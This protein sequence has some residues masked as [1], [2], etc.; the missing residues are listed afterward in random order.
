MPAIRDFSQGYHAGT[1]LRHVEA[2]MPAYEAGDLLL[3]IVSID[4]SA[5][6]TAQ[7]MVGGIPVP[8]IFYNDDTTGTPAWTDYTV[9]ANT[10]SAVWYMTP[11]VPTLNDCINF[12]SLE[13]FSQINVVITTAATA[14]TN[15]VYA[16]QYWNGAWT[17]LTTTT[18]TF[19]VNLKP[20]N[21]VHAE[22]IWA[23]PADWAT[24]AVNGVTAYWVRWICTTANTYTVRGV[25]TQA[26]IFPVPNSNNCWRQLF[27]YYGGTTPAPTTALWKIASE[28]EVDT[29]FFYATAE[30][31]DVELISMR[32]VQIF[33]DSGVAAL[34]VNVVA[35]AGTYIRTT[36]S[37]VTNGFA[38][39]MQISPS[40]F[41]NATNNYTRQIS[42]ITT[43]TNTNDTI[44]VTNVTGLVNETGGGDERIMAWPFNSDV[45]GGGT[46]STF[47]G[48]V[49]SF[50]A[51]AAGRGA[52]PQI[53][54]TKDECLLIYAAVPDA[55]SAPSIIEGPCQLIAGKDGTA[56]A[57]GMA[58]GYQKTAG[59][60]P[61]NVYMSQA[62]AAASGVV[63]E[64]A[65]IA[66][67]PPHTGATV[68]PGYGI[69]D[70]SVY[71]SPYTGAAYG[72]DSA[73]VSA[74][75]AFIGTINGRP[76]SAQSVTF[77]T[78]ADTGLNSYHA[79]TNFSGIVTAGTYG[80]TNTTIATRSIAGKNV[81]FHI[82]TYLP[83][84]I[85]TTDSV[86]LKGACGVVLGLAS[87]TSI[88]KVWHVGGSGVYGDGQRHQPV[89]INTS[90]TAGC[91]CYGGSFAVS[92]GSGTFVA[93][94]RIYIGASW[95]TAT[96]RAKIY[97]VAGTTPTQTIVYN[98]MELANGAY[99]PD[100][101]AS[102]AVVE[103]TIANANGA[104]GTAGTVTSL[105]G[106]A[107][108]RI[109]QYVSGKVVVANWLVGSVW[110][111]DTFTVI[112][113]IAAEPLNLPQIV[114]CYS[115][116]HERK[117][118]IQQGAGQALFLGPVQIG[119]GT[120]FT[121]LNLDGT[122]IE[123]PKQY[124]KAAKQVFYNSVDNVCG[125]K[126][127]AA[128][129][130]TIIHKNSV[131]SS[132]SRYHWGFNS[133]YNTSVTPDF[134]GLSVIGAGTIT[135]NRAVT[136]T[137]LTINDYSTLDVSGL[138][139]D[140]GTIK[141]VPA[142]SASITTTT[143]T[144][145]KRSSI[146]V[147][148]VTAG[149]YWCT[150][151][152][153]VIFENITWTGGGGHAIRITTPGS[154]TLVGNVFNSFGANGTTGAAILNE[155]G[156]LVTITVSSGG[157]GTTY[158]NA[159]GSESTTIIAGAVDLAINVKDI[160]SGS[161]LQSARVLVEVASGVNFPYNASITA[162]A[163]GTTATIAHTGHGLITGKKINVKGAN[164]IEY[165]GVHSITYIGV[166]SYSYTMS[167]SP[168]SPATGTIT[169]TMVLIDAATDV[170]GNVLDNRTYGVNQPIT[171]K[172][173][174]AT[175]PDFYKN[176]P[177]SGTINK[178]SG[179]SLS[180]QMI[181]DA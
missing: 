161:N 143:G 46:G 1:A 69:S 78:R 4:D 138:T 41:T 63:T 52:L 27:A 107:V 95:A 24:T 123:F 14:T 96:K 40:G 25:Y 94:S 83:I 177:V 48:Y 156:G 87:A 131:I 19:G 144:L 166:D 121:Y 85:Q 171:G 154:Y 100:F 122:A 8:Y 117:S 93:T 16:L 18:N 112:G 68:R 70:S 106:G 45:S 97:S 72:S 115:T 179:L 129:G 61:N 36:G 139:F 11:T 38:V 119:D 134:S 57:D 80:G 108:V 66:V 181:P 20:V 39:G 130:D 145:I 23:V 51:A 180:V 105:N 113:G 128:A 173:R 147:S 9:E 50:L 172:V 56:H 30:T 132:S 140:Q 124:D 28:I 151:T 21:T 26:W 81:L 101:A 34:T 168:A 155:S 178:D 162:T 109:G 111:L 103:Y 99:S 141:N 120:N 127:F 118:A 82:Q 174:L 33:A 74:L 163:S 90:A 164:Q 17:T 137:G 84:D 170:N 32:D 165:N 60:T 133:S 150:T 125:L 43:T 5:G 15:P 149:N 126:Y 104:T 59:T 157:S 135:L 86:T 12:G 53:T 54:T 71:I 55:I 44:T 37:W 31:A 148:R 79:M 158:R 152:T 42:T 167:G 146:D 116:G 49:T 153:P 102:D 35:A 65:T 73:P 62:L 6:I 88:F 29:T 98:T 76:I 64:L 91:L 175:S 160:N 89:I 47:S 136:V 114:S 13:K 142:T 159:T 58:W 67:N 110:A 176:S 77:V 2:P 7:N 22:A 10:R 169:A 3:S 75:S 92:G